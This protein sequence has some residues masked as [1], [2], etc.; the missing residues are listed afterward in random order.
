MLKVEECCNS[1]KHLLCNTNNNTSVVQ[2]A[3][4]NNTSQC[5][6]ILLAVLVDRDDHN[7]LFAAAIKHL[8]LSHQSQR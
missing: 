3:Y 6:T 4:K 7:P 8:V 1:P 2:P 5:A